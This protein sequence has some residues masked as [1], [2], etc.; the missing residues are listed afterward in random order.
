MSKFEH[1]ASGDEDLRW[2]Q[3]AKIDYWSER[4]RCWVPAEITCVEPET[5][6]VFIDVKPNQSFDLQQKTRRLR[7]RTKPKESHMGWLWTVLTEGRIEKEAAILFERHAR[8][9]PA[10]EFSALS[11]VGSEIDHLLGV[12]GTFIELKRQMECLE[13]KA[14]T[15]DAFT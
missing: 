8:G 3:G 2:V 5:G 1:A 13:D 9:P 11:K 7:P 6:E 15:L 10:L 14:F 12:R 4:Q